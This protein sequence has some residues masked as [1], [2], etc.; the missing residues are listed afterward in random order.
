MPGL[1]R[2]NWDTGNLHVTAVP[3]RASLRLELE[4]AGRI[5]QPTGHGTKQLELAC[6]HHPFQLSQE[7]RA[8]F[9]C[10]IILPAC[11]FFA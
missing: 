4:A 10:I 2:A 8:S 11:T 1:P 9:A 6:P 7:D 5:Y 3:L